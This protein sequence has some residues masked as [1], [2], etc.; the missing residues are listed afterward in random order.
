LSPR[1]PRTDEDVASAKGLGLAVERLR[2]EHRLAREQVAERGGLPVAAVVEVEAAEAKREPTWGDVRRVAQGLGVELEHL[3]DL[4]YELAP[5]PAGERLR[6]KEL[7]K[8][9]SDDAE[10]LLVEDEP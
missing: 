10:R 2:R 6:E 8:A 4:S 3:I 1:R 9:R 5:G 7:Q